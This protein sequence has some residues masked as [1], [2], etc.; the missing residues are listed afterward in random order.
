VQLLGY[1]TLTRVIFATRLTDRAVSFVAAVLLIVLAVAVVAAERRLRSDDAP[2]DWAAAGAGDRVRLGRWRF[3]AAAGAWLLVTVGLIVPLGSLVLWA[4]RG[5]FAGRL[6][7]ARLI[8]P[9]VNT[10]TAGLVT[11]VVAVVIVVPIA[12]LTVRYRSRAATIAAVSVIAGFAVPGIVIALALVFWSLNTPVVWVLYQTFPLLVLAYVIHFGSQALGAAETAV[13]A[14]PPSLRDSARLLEV[15]AA[16]RRRV[17]ELPLMRP[18]LLSGGGLVMLATVKELP[19]T[20]LLAPIGFKTLATEVWGAYE[21]GFFAQAGA[22]SI[23]LI[24]VSG[25]LTW[26]LVLRRQAQ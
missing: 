25:A 12:V 9:V 19:V 10:A 15:S 4:A 18:G 22:A 20:L 1:D 14:V 3:V 26:Q 17:I 23:V 8:T 11:A 24:I 21:E 6:D 5:L 16:R 2:D 7:L 13:R